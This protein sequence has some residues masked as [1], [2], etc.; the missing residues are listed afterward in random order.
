MTD[1]TDTTNSAP[2]VDAPATQQDAP[3]VA[4]PEAAADEG[5]A[6]GGKVVEP[7]E[8]AEVTADIPEK[9]ELA[10]EGI[11]LDQE[12]LEAADPVFRE[13]S[14]SN[15]QA[16]KLMPV[17][18]AFA[19]KTQAATLQQIQDAARQQTADWLA[20][21][22]RDAEIGGD[23]WNETTAL[24]AKGMDALGFNEQHPFRQF[25]NETGLGNHR[26][27]LF[28]FRRLGET[29]AED[30]F[31]RGKGIPAVKADVAK[32]LYPND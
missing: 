24:A 11:D 27:M 20:I 22:K 2:A 9:Y 17:A 13:L 30:S 25:L 19:E 10:V 31:E 5:T 8:T 3:A 18:K 7:A 14:L 28:A 12:M 23:K 26:D 6:L 4:A 1:V 29:V 15:E 16:N 32:Q 21:A